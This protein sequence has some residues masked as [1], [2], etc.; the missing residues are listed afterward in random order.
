M[1]P[2]GQQPYHL[3]HVKNVQANSAPFVPPREQVVCDNDGAGDVSR[4]EG[5]EGQWCGG[6]VG[7]VVGEKTL[8]YFGEVVDAH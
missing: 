3:K 1:P 2:R 8:D 7:A 6:G 5:D 4:K